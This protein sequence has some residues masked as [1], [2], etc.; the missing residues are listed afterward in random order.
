[1]TGFPGFVEDSDFNMLK[2]VTLPNPWFYYAPGWSQ[3]S[4]PT[5]S[6]VNGTYTVTLPTTTTERW[7]AQMAFQTTGVSVSADKKYDFSVIMTSTTE[8]GGVKVK[9]CD[10]SDN[11]I[12][13]DKDFT[14]EANEPKALWASGLDGVDISDLKIVFDFGG[15]AENTAINIESFVLKDHANDDGTEVPEETA[16]PFDYNDSNNIWKAIDEEQAFT[17]EFWFGDANWGAIECT[18]EVTHDGSTHTITIPVETP[19][20]EWH[21]QWKL[22]TDLS[23]TADNLVDFSLK[24]SAKQNGDAVKLPG[25]TVKLTDSSNDDNYFFAERQEIPTDGYVLRFEDDKLARGT[26]ASKLSLVFDFGGAPE[27]AVVTINEITL[28]KK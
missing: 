2:G 9:L 15:N 10:S 3:I 18:P 12:L 7:Q 13:M 25:M 22:H 17:E 26:D 8:H 16:T 28:I 19:A 20:E 11:I 27:G 24:V 14:L 21:A 1:M 4:D 6:L 5:W 23:A